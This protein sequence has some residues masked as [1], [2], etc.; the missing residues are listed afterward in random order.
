M[1]NEI[2]ITELPIEWYTDSDEIYSLEIWKKKR[3]K[4]IYINGSEGYK[5]PE[6]DVQE[7]VNYWLSDEG[8]NARTESFYRAWGFYD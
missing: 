8:R 6:W 2:E 1:T 4:W 3:T 5:M 7:A